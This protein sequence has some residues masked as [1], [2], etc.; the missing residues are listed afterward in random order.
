[1]LTL[2]RVAC[3]GVGRDMDADHR[4]QQVVDGSTPR[5]YC[6]CVSIDLPGAVEEQLRTLAEKQGRDIGAIVEDAIRQY[7]DAAAITDLTGD[8][9]AATQAALLGELPRVPDWKAGDE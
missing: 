1:M 3:D 7:L 4:V 2:A 8:E 5:E 6:R 9:I